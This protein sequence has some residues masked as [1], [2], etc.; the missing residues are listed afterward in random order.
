MCQG[1]FHKCLESLDGF[2]LV[3]ISGDFFA[4]GLVK[5]MENGRPCAILSLGNAGDIEV[6]QGPGSRR[7]VGQK[8]LVDDLFNRHQSLLRGVS[9]HHQFTTL[10]YPDIAVSVRLRAVEDGEVRFQG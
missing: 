5:P 3:G 9:H 2:R 1:P 10:T 6:T 7:L 4:I 8:I